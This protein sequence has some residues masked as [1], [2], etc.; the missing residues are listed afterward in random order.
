[1][2]WNVQII[3]LLDFIVGAANED[4]ISG[5]FVSPADRAACVPSLSCGSQSA[6]LNPQVGHF[7][8]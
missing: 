1:M 6:G 4:R 8:V 7:W 5:G 2:C 3:S